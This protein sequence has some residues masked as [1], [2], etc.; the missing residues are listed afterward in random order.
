MKIQTVSYLKSNAAKLDL[1]EPMVITQNG[2]PSYVI[3]SYEDRKRRDDAIALM[4]LL[5]FSHEDKKHGKVVS[6]ASFKSM[7]A[8]RKSKVPLN[9]EASKN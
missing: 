7:L 3:E 5:S 4:K 2:I 1:E 9:D 6:S 8:E